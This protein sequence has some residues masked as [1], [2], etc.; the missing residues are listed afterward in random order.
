MA[1]IFQRIFLSKSKLNEIN[2]QQEIM[3]LVSSEAVTHHAYFTKSGAFVRRFSI[4]TPTH[5]I[6]TERSYEKSRPVEHEVQY[7]LVVRSDK[8]IVYA[9]HS[10]I[11]KFTQQ[12]YNKMYKIWDKKKQNAK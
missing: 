8:H 4:K 11:D 12:V 10:E 3:K 6:Y 9:T 2:K 1:T 7:S 5:Q